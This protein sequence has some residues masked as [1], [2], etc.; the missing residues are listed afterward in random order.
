M[1]YMR[2]FVMGVPWQL[3]LSMYYPITVSYTHLDVYKRQIQ[4]PANSLQAGLSYPG[5]LRIPCNPEYFIR[6]GIPIWTIR[7]F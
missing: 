3:Y 5:F 6:S 4:K 1:G 2:P 7:I